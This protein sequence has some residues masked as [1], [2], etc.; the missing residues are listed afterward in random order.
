MKK[1]YYLLLTLA[2]SSLS[3]GQEVFNLA[4]GGAFPT[5]W[6]A[7]NN[8][9]TNDIDRG[10][11]FLLDSGDPSDIIV[12]AVYDLSAYSSAE[13]SLDVAT[14]GSGDNNS[15]TI[16]FSYDG[17]TTYTQ[18]ETS[19]VA[20]SSS[21]IDGGSFAVTPSAQVVIKLTNTG[22][23]GKGNRL[24]N[25]V[26]TGVS[27][28]TAPT[29]NAP[30]PEA[31]DA[32]DVISIYSDAYS[33][34]AV[35]NFNP[36]WGQSGSVDAAYD[37]T[38][39]GTNTVLAYTNFNY[40]GTEFGNQDA[41]AMEY[42]HVDVWTAT[43]GAVLKVTPINNGTGT[44]EVLADVALVN[45]GWSSVDIPKATF[46]GMTWDSVFQLKFDGQA[47][48]NPSDV[49]IDNIYFWKEPTA[50]GTDVTLSD[51]TLDGTTI[52]GFSA[53]ATS[54]TVDLVQ[55]TTTAP[56]IAAVPT[57][58]NA[59]VAVTDATSVPGSG[60]VLV[61]A[62][63]GITTS[64]VTVNFTATIP[65]DGAPAPTQAEEDVVSVYSDTYSTNILTNNNPFW[66]QATQV[67][68]VQLGASS[69]N[70][71]KYSNLNYQGMLYDATDVSSMD[72][73][74]LDY[75][76]NDATALEFFVIKE[77]AGEN[78][79][80]IAG[81]LG[82]TT[83]EWVSVDIPL[84]HY[85]GTDLTGVN[86]F[87]TV[88]NGTVYIDNLFFW[89]EPTTVSGPPCT[90]TLVMNDQYNDTW[91]G[92]SV[93]ILVNG[94]VVASTTGPANGVADDTLTFD[95][96][97]GDTI[98]LDNWSSGSYDSEISWE[99]LD[100][101]GSSL[102]SG[103]F[104]DGTA[105]LTAYCTPP[106]PCPHTLVMNDQYND[107]WDGASVDI[108]VN[109][110]VVASTTGPA[111]GV[112][113]DTLAFDAASGDTIALGNWSSGSYDSEIS[114]AILDGAGTEIAA[115]GFGEGTTEVTGYCPSCLDP[116]DL[117]VSDITTATASV[118]WTANNGETAWEYQVVAGGATPAET[119]DA[120]SD[121]PLAL[122]GLTANTT[123]DVYVR[124]NCG[125]GV[126]SA[127]VMISFTTECDA[128]TAFP[129]TEDFDTDWSCWSVVNADGD[130]YT[131]SQSATYIT[132]R[133]GSSTAH[134]MGSNNDYLISPKF[135]LTGNERVVW[136]DIVES[137]TRNNTYDVLLSTTGKEISDFTVNL[138]T[139][140]CT[141][142]SWSEHIL[143][144]SAYS[145]DVYIALHQTYSAS[146]FYGFGVDDFTI[147][148]NPSCISPTDLSASGITTTGAVVSWVSDGTAFLIEIQPEGSL[149]GT[150]GG[151]VI[152]DVD[153]YPTT[154]VDL[155]GYLT[156]GT[157]YDIYVTNVCDGGNSELA[158][159]LTF[160]TFCEVASGAWS[161][162]FDT[163]DDCW[164][165][166]N[167]GDANTWV[168]YD[169]SANGGG[170]ASYAITYG[171]TAHDDYLISPAFTVTDEVTDRMSFDARNQSTSFLESIDVQIWN[172]DISVLLETVATGVT[173]S[174][175]YETFTYDLSA[176]EGQDIR[177]AFYISTTDQFRIYI[178]NVVVDGLLGLEDV[179]TSSN[180][181]Y[182]PN[183][184][185]NV[186]S[187]KAQASI[188]SISVYNM[189]G[190]TVVRSTPNT[191]TTAVDMSGL[192]TGAYFVQV[193]INNSIETVRVIKN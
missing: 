106:P 109:G 66:G 161:N 75:Y 17:G 64:T 108:L 180:F 191:T 1:I 177:F 187:I 86:Q 21:Y 59:T 95:A 186:L 121:N 10:S 18:S 188:D 184:V 174:T 12:S 110:T 83:G 3:F 105:G 72:Y 24:R 124:A 189:L 15:A 98:S 155:T 88:G 101:E 116:S 163:N 169:D 71:L 33:S 81:T 87:K 103:G 51:L 14:F 67:T 120:T 94:T 84:A 93:D 43:A 42:L 134:G 28:P 85:T 144:L 76:T 78:T 96:A 138:G 63:D 190:Q 111:N 112:A 80:D 6:T 5:G 50:A 132:P 136:Y 82:I 89:T 32:A 159:P 115:G 185:N 31:R 193:A 26:L 139:Y 19:A 48:T 181:T 47:G 44:A 140:D 170:V 130:S 38:G 102:G 20:T 39:E 145:G 56:S 74:H 27:S 22:V 9:T 135:T 113:D 176:Y 150:P 70:T 142:V 52:A 7:T 100:G 152:G 29:T 148:E 178:D 165:V 167:G 172:A 166:S 125:D 141:N 153:P 192:Q 13:F 65:A 157:S 60:S 40:Q 123:Y 30:T 62:A 175:A 34:I 36:F 92:A 114:W 49:Y 99:L 97:S 149:P 37:P 171:S 91:D 55:G 45:A 151:Y 61:T 154:S 117:A 164:L 46:A 119:G 90:H 127:W 133:S 168:L 54:Y 137:A 143:D 79:Y 16:E 11:Y 68:E 182:F 8:V 131:W 35:G 57:D 58:S 53:G 129:Y 118:S 25:L 2:I 126:T 156:P 183:P 41:S 122:T 104:G 158:G 146:T 147:M 4:G 69:N 179:N 160:T 77:G 162:D 73:V 128:I 23:T 107:T 173:P